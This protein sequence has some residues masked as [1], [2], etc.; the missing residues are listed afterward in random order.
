MRYYAKN[1][2]KGYGDFPKATKEYSKE[3]IVK[4]TFAMLGEHD[5]EESYTD[6]TVKKFGTEEQANH[7][8]ACKELRNGLDD[9]WSEFECAGMVER[10]TELSEEISGEIDSVVSSVI[11]N[12]LSESM[13]SPIKICEVELI[14]LDDDKNIEEYM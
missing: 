7:Y 9:L 8:F 4:W 2:W 12:A 10:Y 1:H 13:E 11:G 6:E 14:A 5:P 3:H